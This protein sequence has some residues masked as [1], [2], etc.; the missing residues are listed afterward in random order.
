MEYVEGQPITD[1]CA[2]R[3]MGTRERLV[4]FRTVC[5]AVQ[6]AHQNLVVHR[7]IKPANVLVD[8]HGSAKLLDFGIAKLLA[9]GVE[10]ELAP[11]AT[12]LPMLTP[13]Y[14]S[15][16]QVRGQPVTTASDVY[17]LGVL[18]YELLAGRRPYEVQKDSLEAIVQAVCRTEPRPPSEAVTDRSGA[19]RPAGTL[20]PASELRGDLDT[21]VLKALRKEPE[22]RYRTAHELSE[23]LRRYLEGLPVTARA[24]T[25]GYRAGKF[26]RRHRTAVAA[27]FL[28]SASLVAG[29]VT[30]TRQARLAQR[31]FDEARRLIRTVIFDIQPKMGAVAGTTPLRKELIESTLHYLEALARDAGDNP[32]LLRELSA[33]YVQLARV[34]GLAGDAN[35]GDVHAARRTLGEAQKLVERLLK[36]DPDGP[37]SLHEAVSLERFVAL[38]FL[39]E[40]AYAPAQRHAR[41]AVELAERLVEIRPDFPA[42][43]DLADAHRTLANCSDSAE[44]FGR[45]R[46]IYESL[47][48]E[49]P[50][51]PRILRSLSQVHKYVAGLHYRKREDRS[52]LDLIVKARAI[53]E[54]LLAA[55]PENPVAQM[56]LSFSLNQLSWGYS[57][58][59]NLAGALAA[60]Q[61]SLAMQE[62]ILARN[63]GEARVQ[64]RVGYALR[65]MALLRRKSGD[66]G[67][68]RR[69]YLRARAIYTELRARGYG[70]AYV[71]TELGI[72]ELELG[73]LAA[74][75]RR[76]AEACQWYRRS[77]ALFGELVAQGALR[78]DSHEEADKARRAA[79]ACGP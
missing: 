44:A 13:E 54:K 3:G 76:P 19:T 61:E 70:G 52:G 14:A 20:P 77:A 79:A 17:S 50:D 24:D 34:Q 12:A 10:P 47:L 21:I 46:E 32:A 72:T 55:N 33:S 60:I 51:E 4:L 48:L 56:D 71:G 75:E 25:I 69:D 15:P 40:A 26:V 43:E 31:R 9:S 42:R 11:T 16:E 37:E 18:L 68:A 27:A 5:G 22:R 1:F 8:G 58:L 57:R 39:Y 59:G 28:V 38:S 49:K 30:T 53:D 35:V 6:Y 23:D 45:S 65:A 7:D 41:R 64:D 63:P 62:R 36:L 2:A 67:A 66:R 74:E 78:S 73:D 29:I